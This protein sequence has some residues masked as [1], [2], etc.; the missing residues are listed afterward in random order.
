MSDSSSSVSD[1]TDRLKKSEQLN[2]ELRAVEA[3]LKRS[4]AESSAKIAELKKDVEHFKRTFTS[5]TLRSGFSSSL[6]LFAHT[7]FSSI[8]IT[9]SE[10][11]RRR[12]TELWKVMSI[13]ISPYTAAQ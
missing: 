7:V 9:V 12:H 8:A 5:P 4:N 10:R 11:C 2:S 6:F 3:K 1:L 13:F